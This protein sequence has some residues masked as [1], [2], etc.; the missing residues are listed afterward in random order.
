[1]I[2]LI[3]ARHGNT[4][5]PEDTPTRV[6][7]R[8]DIPLVQSGIEQAALIGQYFRH[9]Q[10]MPDVIYSSELKR[11]QQTA[12]HALLN[13]PITPLSCFNEID[14]GPDENQTENE[15]VARIGQ[16]A[17]DAWNQHAIVPDGWQVNPDAIIQNWL[18][19]GAMIQREHDNQTVFVVTSNGIARFAPYLTGDFK[20]FSEKH[21][22][23]LKTGALS[24]FRHFDDA[25]HVDYWNLRP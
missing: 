8:T 11:T 4:F 10:I 16:P 20:T 15:V 23:K 7:A 1:M 5:G 21:T 3:I 19:F 17:I 2:Q 22:I 25:W 18:D 9:H 13:R 6:G 12:E 24:S 14:Y